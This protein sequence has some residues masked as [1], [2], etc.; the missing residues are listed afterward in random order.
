MGNVCSIV[1]QYR[2]WEVSDA[3]EIEVCIREAIMCTAIDG[4][5]HFPGEFAET[6]VMAV[7]IF[8]KDMKEMASSGTAGA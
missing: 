1:I 2:S 4:T 5:P 7:V 3:V 8:G 6:I